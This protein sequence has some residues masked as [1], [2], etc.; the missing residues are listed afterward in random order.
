MTCIVGMEYEDKVY[1]GADSAVWANGSMRERRGKLF[2]LQ[3]KFIIGT[4]GS[5]RM[6]QIIQYHVTPSEQPPG[7]G[8]FEYLVTEVASKI[9][10]ALKDHAHTETDGNRELQDGS[11]LIG[12][13]SKLYTLGSDFCVVRYD[14]NIA[15]CGSGEQYALASMLTQSN[16]IHPQKRILKALQISAQLSD[17]VRP[18]FYVECL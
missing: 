12:Y 17:S 1:I 6:G 10:L 7:M 11:C 14:D 3:N 15:A 4:C 2:T 18:P 5:L 16:R 13:K 9:R 8:D